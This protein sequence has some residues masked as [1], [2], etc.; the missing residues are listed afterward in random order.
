MA[1]HSRQKYWRH[2]RCPIAPSVFDRDP[3]AYLD[4]R[5]IESATAVAPG[6]TQTI[7][8]DARSFA[9]IELFKSS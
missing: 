2:E 6:Q 8:I 3:A 5:V 4:G 7:N 1:V 9:A